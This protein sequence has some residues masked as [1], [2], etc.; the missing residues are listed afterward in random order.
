MN[1]W[2]R[3]ILLPNF[4]GILLLKSA[5]SLRIYQR[6]TPLQISWWKP[7]KVLSAPS[8]MIMTLLLE[9]GQ[10]DRW[11]FLVQTIMGWN[12]TSGFLHHK[13]IYRKK[14]FVLPSIGGTNH[15]SQGPNLHQKRTHPRSAKYNKIHFYRKHEASSLF[16][17]K[18]RRRQSSVVRVIT[19]TA[20]THRQC[21]N[22]SIFTSE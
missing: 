14:L 16:T 7:Q 5:K 17:L 1:Q 8:N 4:Q 11:K 9:Y 19:P 22:V 15:R 10:G 12:I 20:T 2:R 18:E 13:N 21:S 3:V 6:S